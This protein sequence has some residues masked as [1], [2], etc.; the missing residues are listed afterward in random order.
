MDKLKLVQQESKS[1]LLQ[2]EA[3]PIPADYI[4][5]GPCSWIMTSGDRKGKLCKDKAFDGNK[6]CSSHLIP[7]TRND[8]KNGIVTP[9]HSTEEK[10]A[11][12]IDVVIKASKPDEPEIKVTETIITS[13]E[14]I[15]GDKKC[16]RSFMPNGEKYCHKCL[17]R[18]KKKE[19][20]PK[21]PDN[22]PNETRIIPIPPNNP[23]VEIMS[24]E[25]L[26]I[27][28]NLVISVTNLTEIL[29]K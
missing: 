21:V 14:G 6:Y 24:S 13:C 18:N 19:D 15:K 7:G 25:L 1:D 12:Q 10:K 28:R 9:E 26:A 8:V 20:I 4:P 3:M 16:H 2:P 17:L 22:P 27:F 11:T 23:P 29:K 5:P